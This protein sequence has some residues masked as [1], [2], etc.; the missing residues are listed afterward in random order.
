MSEREVPVSEKEHFNEGFQQ[1]KQDG[2][3]NKRIRSLSGKDIG[4]I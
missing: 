3:R 1:K 2:P 4:I